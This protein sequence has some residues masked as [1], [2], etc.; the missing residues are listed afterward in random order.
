M[1]VVSRLVRRSSL[2]CPVYDI[3][4]GKYVVIAN[5]DGNATETQGI[6]EFSLHEPM[7]SN[8]K[9]EGGILP[10]ARQ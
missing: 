5:H 6:E 1:R 4:E 2:P 10:M 8:H 3:L 7:L 9:T